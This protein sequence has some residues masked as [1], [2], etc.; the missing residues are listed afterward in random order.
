MNYVVVEG[1]PAVGKSEAL[2][3]LARF[4]PESVRVLPELV[5]Q[6]VTDRGLD[7]FR[8][9]DALTA[10]IAAALPERTTEILDIVRD[11]FVCLEESHLDVHRAYSLA[12]GDT[13]FVDAFEPLRAALPPPDA[14]VRLEIPVQRSLER[15]RRSSAG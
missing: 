15:R 2:A 12:L 3:L 6:I 1:L 11:G 9:R 4:Y 7:L 14:I 10:A 5:K 8:Q 13:T